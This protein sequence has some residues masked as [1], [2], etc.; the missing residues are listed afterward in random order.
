MWVLVHLRESRSSYGWFIS[1]TEDDYFQGQIAQKV[2][3]SKV[4]VRPVNAAL[5]IALKYRNLFATVLAANFRGDWLKSMP[6]IIS[7]IAPGAFWTSNGF[8]LQILKQLCCLKSEQTPFFESRSSFR[9][10]YA[11]CELFLCLTFTQKPMNDRKIE[12]SES[13][14]FSL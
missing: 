13:C 14:C 10:R 11:A 3:E 2:F 9:F 1:N 12:R 5:F 6:E 7:N 4:E 8:T